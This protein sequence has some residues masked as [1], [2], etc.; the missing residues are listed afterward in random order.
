[1]AVKPEENMSN[2]HCTL[3]Q[4][5]F[6]KFNNH[7]VVKLRHANTGKFVRGSTDY[8]HYDGCLTL[9]PKLQPD[10]NTDVCTFIDWESIVMLPDVIRI[11]G[12]NGNHLRACA[13]GFMDFQSKA[14]NSSMY[15]YEVSPSRDG[16]IRLKSTHFGTYWMDMDPVCFVWLQQADPTDLATNTIF[17]PV[18]LDR[19]RIIMRSLKDGNICK[20]YDGNYWRDGFSK[21]SCLATSYNYLEESCYMEIEEP[22][23]RRTI[24]NVRYQLTDARIYNERTLALITD[25]SRNR[26]QHPQTS[27]IN[28][29]TTVTNTTN[30]SNSVS[31]KE[32][33]KM[34]G[35]FG[36]PLIK[37]GSL[38][39]SSE[40][41][42][43]WNWEKMETESIEVG[44]V[45]TV[46]VPPMSRVKTSLI[47]T[48][49]S[50][51]I[52]FSYT[53]RDVLMNGNTKVSQ[54][55]DGLFNGDNGYNYNYEVV[56]LPL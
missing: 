44:S 55:N 9:R 50:Y 20:R 11:K 52:P 40:S 26:T 31:F 19:N 6:L 25:D 24:S 36:V 16:G 54:K 15:D 41:T 49:C 27:Q 1:M 45:R 30:W 21:Q 13:D 29:K 18:K 48:W 35:T 32:G 28:I 37:S 14:D 34:T 53:Q 5:V 2:P 8:N 42:K 4:P 23:C 22:V 39:I 51:D 56:E 10:D 3:F 46:T 7:H 47:A 12:D 33:V 17:L 43:S 38:E